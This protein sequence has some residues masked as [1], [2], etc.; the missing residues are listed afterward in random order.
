MPKTWYGMPANADANGKVVVF[1]QN[2]SKFKYRYSTLG[3]QDSARLD[4][5]QMWATSY[6][7]MKLTPADEKKIAALVKKAVR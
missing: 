2:A 7:L 6:A 3:F 4:D 5:G 1:F